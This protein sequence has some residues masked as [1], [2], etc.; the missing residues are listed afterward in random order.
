M[1]IESHQSLRS[2]PKLLRLAGILGVSEPTAVG[3]LHYLWWWCLDYAEDGNL[4]AYTDGEI[5]KAAGWTR[6]SAKFVQA[7]TAAN[8]LDGKVIHD[9]NEYGGRLMH[10]REQSRNRMR[11]LRARSANVQQTYTPTV[12]YSTV[13]NNSSVCNARAQEEENLPVELPKGFPKTLH[14]A[15]TFASPVGCTEDLTAKV[16]NAAMSRNGRDAKGN[17]ITSFQHHLA[18]AKAYD[19]DRKERENK[20]ANNKPVSQQRVNRNLGTSN[21]KIDPKLYANIGKVA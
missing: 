16:W 12:Q 10:K 14:D 1:W 18:A 6:D 19:L 15:L 20:N 3:H 2:H 17:P 5:A 21:E 13:H 9:W 11:T 8:W 7:L 4:E